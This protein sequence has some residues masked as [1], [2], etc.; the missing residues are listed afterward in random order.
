MTWKRFPHNFMGAI[1]R[2]FPWRYLWCYIEQFVE[3]TDKL[4]SSDT[5]SHNDNN[6]NNNDDDDDDDDDDNNKQKQ[7]QQQ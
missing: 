3:Q 5:P 1:H 6:D 2:G 7:Q 4:S